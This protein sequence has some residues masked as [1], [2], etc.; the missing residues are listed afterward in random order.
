MSFPA[1]SKVSRGVLVDEVARRFRGPLTRYFG[2][3]VRRAADVEDLVQEVF[4]RLA[5]RAEETPVEAIDGYVFAVAGSVLVDSHRKTARQWPLTADDDGALQV[6]EDR[7]PERILL[8]QE[9]LAAMERALVELPERTRVVFVLNRFEEFTY[10]EI[11]ARLDVS[12]SAIEKHMM[13]ALA[14]LARRRRDL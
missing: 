10:Q 5:R 11:A 9:Q 8:G 1:E 12:V 3:R 7:S 6:P 4:L 13:R 14:H 2:A